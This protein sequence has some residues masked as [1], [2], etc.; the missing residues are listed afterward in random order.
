MPE[1]NSAPFHSNPIG[2]HPQIAPE[3][4]QKPELLGCLR[5]ALRAR[6]SF[7]THLLEGGYDIRTVQELLGHND[8]KTTMI[9]THVLNRGPAGVRSPVDGL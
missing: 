8:V 5:E 4:A 7:A 3:P 2:L 6:R 1:A 9:Y